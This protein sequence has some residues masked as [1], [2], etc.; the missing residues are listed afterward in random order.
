MNHKNIKT[1]LDLL[2]EMQVNVTAMLQEEASPP[3]PP[4]KEKEY[5]NQKEAAKFLGVSV[6]T[7]RL[8]KIDPMFPRASRIR[9]Q[10]RYDKEDLILFLR[11][12]K[13]EK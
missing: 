13:D 9:K 8:L 10:Y 1:L 11:L 2:Q 12:K 3:P 5:L 6:P 4:K 7:F